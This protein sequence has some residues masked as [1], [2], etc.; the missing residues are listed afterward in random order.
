MAQ[1]VQSE[2]KRQDKE[3]NKV[4]R[5]MNVGQVL[6]DESS[7]DE[8]EE[9]GESENEEDGDM[10]GTPNPVE[11]NEE[12][13]QV[14]PAP[15]PQNLISKWEVSYNGKVYTGYFALCAGVNRAIQ[16]SC[17]FGLAF[18]LHARLLS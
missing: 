1:P 14:D 17:E 10:A 11:K 18:S 15:A 4:E 3:G 8:E 6:E 7:S 9:E 13:M 2:D 16:V 5:R 12:K